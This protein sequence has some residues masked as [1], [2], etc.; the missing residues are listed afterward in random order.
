MVDARGLKDG[1][2]A[3]RTVSKLNVLTC[4]EGLANKGLIR[5]RGRKKTV[6]GTTAI[7]IGLGREK[8]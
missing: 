1:K 2:C 3:R 6:T 8:N 5:E 4:L 7:F